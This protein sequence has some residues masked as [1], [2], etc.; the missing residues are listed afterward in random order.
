MPKKRAE[1]VRTILEVCSA[2]NGTCAG[3][4]RSCAA[5]D[6]CQKRVLMVG[7]ITKM[8]DRY[9]EVVEMRGGCLRISRRLYSKRG[10]Q[11]RRGYPQGRYGALPGELQ[12]SHC[13]R[14][15]EESRQEVRKACL[16]ARRFERQR[17]RPGCGAR[18]SARVGVTVY[19]LLWWYH[20]L[21]WAYVREEGVV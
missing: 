18:R 20:F 7:G 1:K 13:V 4:G 21:R 9:R 11:S 10:S 5:C 16:H 2:S 6:L 19:F 8:E 3:C 15:R 12:Q 14:R 17:T